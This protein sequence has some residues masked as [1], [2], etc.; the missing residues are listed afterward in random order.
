MRFRPA[1]A[2]HVRRAGEWC[3]IH[4]RYQAGWVVGTQKSSSESSQ[5]PSVSWEA[6]PSPSPK[7]PHTCVTRELASF[8]RGW[9]NLNSRAFWELGQAS[10]WEGVGLA[11]P[12]RSIACKG[13]SVKPGGTGEKDRQTAGSG[14]GRPSGCCGD[15]TTSGR[16]KPATLPQACSCRM[17]TSS[18][19]RWPILGPCG[20]FSAS[21]W[22]TVLNR[23]LCP[24]D[25]LSLFLQHLHTPTGWS[26]L[27]SALCLHGAELTLRKL[28]SPGGGSRYGP[29]LCCRAWLSASLT[30]GAQTLPV[31]RS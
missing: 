13:Q 4:Q 21:L 27:F 1:L 30:L 5:S 19:S 9:F 2:P 22:S 18:F 20:T 28:P 6:S 12:L 25:F 8:G 15:A 10:P 16:L 24:V 17:E 29:P 26:S 23:S 7:G 11:P 14:R 3:V 31:V